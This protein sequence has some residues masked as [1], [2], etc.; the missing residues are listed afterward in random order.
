MKK[1]A[2]LLGMALMLTATQSNAQ[3]I[4]TDIAPDGM[5]AGGGFDF[6]GDGINEFEVD[7]T[8]YFSYDW[9]ATGNNIWAIGTIAD[10]WDTPKPLTAG[11]VIDASGNFIG[12]GDASM[13]A[14]GAGTPFPNGTDSYMGVRLGMAGNTHYGWIRLMWDGAD[15]I[16]KDFAY[17]KTPNML[18]K[19]GEMPVPASV[20]GMESGNS[21]QIF[22]MP[23]I[24]SVTIKNN[25]TQPLTQASILDISGKKIQTISLNG[26]ATQTLDISSLSNGI[27]LLQVRAQNGAVSTQKLIV[28]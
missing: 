20:S 5:P 23:A 15:W 22:P 2:L 13:D 17:E 21:I 12:G 11:T 1:G 14:W 6:N 10:G 3:I 25:G 24:G 4:Y 28:P 16:Y 27:Y 7:E 18:I 9:T 19:A 26:A 8:G